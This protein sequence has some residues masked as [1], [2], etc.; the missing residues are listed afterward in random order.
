MHVASKSP[1]ARLLDAPRVRVPRVRATLRN[2]VNRH[3]SAPDDS[4]LAHQVVMCGS[5][6]KCTICGR[7]ASTVVSL[8]SLL[9]KL[10]FGSVGARVAVATSARF[11]S[12]GSRE[13]L[14]RRQNHSLQVVAGITFCTKCGAYSAKRGQRLLQR[15][16]GVSVPGQSGHASNGYLQR[17][18]HP[19]YP[20]SP[21]VEMGSCL[22]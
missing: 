22:R 14:S 18:L 12:S 8:R 21:L 1:V 3:V 20:H 17:G 10:C 13:A 11:H 9:S 4:V 2:M 16:F 6:A 5:V 7:L 15:C 19:Q